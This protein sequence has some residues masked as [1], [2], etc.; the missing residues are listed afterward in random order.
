VTIKD[1][2]E[3]LLRAKREKPHGGI[4]SGVRE[5]LT[6]DE[7]RLELAQSLTQVVN[8]ALKYDFGN[9]FEIIGEPIFVEILKGFER[10]LEL[11]KEWTALCL[12]EFSR[13]TLKI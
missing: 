6:L 8:S 5:A 13:R 9:S 4:S 12:D 11:S 1:P 3:S 10:Y 2:R 7:A